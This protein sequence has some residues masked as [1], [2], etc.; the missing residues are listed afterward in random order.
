MK[1][2]IILFEDKY[3][4]EIINLKIK[5]FDRRE[6]EAANGFGYRRV[7]QRAVNRYKSTMYLIMYNGTVSGI[8]GAV[9]SPKKGVGI[10]YLLT[11]DRISEYKWDFTRYSIDVVV[12]LLKKYSRITN[13]VSVEHKLSVR[14]LKKIGARFNGKA[15]I[16][17]DPD[18]PFYKF[19]LRKE[20]YYV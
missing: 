19:E 8:F 15:Y 7:L 4:D 14:W 16:L 10:G 13:Y 12:H 5:E 9:D 6:V 2:E 17:E 3:Y 11:D 20:D 1:I 18:I